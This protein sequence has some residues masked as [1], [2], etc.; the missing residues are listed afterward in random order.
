MYSFFIY[1]PERERIGI[2]HDYDCV[3]WLE[4]YQ[5]PGEVKVDAHI[6][7]ENISLLVEGNRIYNPDSD[8]VALIRHV[9]ISE[10]DAEQLIVV[11]AELTARLLDDRVV[12][13]TENVYN[14]EAGMYKIYRDNRR[15]LPIGIAAA[16]GFAERTDTQI[17]WNS[18]LDGELK[19]AEVSR[20]GFKVMFDPATGMEVFKVYKGV[21]RTSPTLPGYIGYLGTDVASIQNPS[22]TSGSTDYKNVAI[23]AGEGEGGDRKV[24]TV[25]LGVYEGEARREQ[26]VDA[27][28]LQQEYQ[29]ATPTGEFDEK[30]NPLYSYDS[31]EYTDS[32]YDA[33]LEN[34]GLEKLAEH[35]R[36][37][38]ISCDIVQNNIRFGEDYHLGDR[39]PVKLPEYGIYATARVSSVNRVYEKEGNAIVAYL[40]EFEL[41]GL[42]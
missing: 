6:T 40:S 3:Q 20:L 38:S 39:M 26:Y 32:E 41:E 29:I 5:S 10:P 14:V 42:E 22:I 15:D 21:D 28:D 24:R 18:V 31:R 13:A 7:P 35:L 27:R 17:T 2:L 16:E 9:E 4:N 37:F 1:N 33:L 12:M 23:V 36:D 19:L 11:H 34:R 25:A 30:G 8:T